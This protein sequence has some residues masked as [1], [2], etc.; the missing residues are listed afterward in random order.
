M[1]TESAGVD[2]VS[3]VT[4]LGVLLAIELISNGIS[5]LILAMSASEPRHV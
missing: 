2:L 3:V 4:L 5:M 1:A